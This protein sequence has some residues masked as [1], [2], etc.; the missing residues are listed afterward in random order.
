MINKFILVTLIFSLFLS[1]GCTNDLASNEEESSSQP[2][3]VTEEDD[4]KISYDVP[5][6]GGSFS[7]NDLIYFIL[8]D[9]FNDGDTSNNN[10]SDVDKNSPTSYHG[11]DL[12]GIIDKLDY[13]K[14][15]GATAIWITP[16]VENE[17]GGYHGYWT[18]DFYRVDPHLGTMEDLK[19]LVSEAHKRDMKIL[20][21][22]IVNHTGYKTSWLSDGKHE[23]WFNPEVNISNFNDQE[24]VEKGWLAGLPDLDQNNP[25]VRKFLLD[26]VMWWIDETNIDGMRLDTVRHVPKD[27]WNEFADTIKSKY[28]DF[29]LLGE[30][31]NNSARY[32]EEYHAL[33][34]DGLTNY[35]LFEG[36]RG[37]FTRF[38]KTSPLINALKEQ[39]DFSNPGISG[40]FIDNH[41]NRRL[42]TAGKEYGQQYHRQALA[43]V[44]T[45]PAIPIIYYGTEIGMEGEDDPDNRRDMEWKKTE[46]SDV[47]TFYKILSELRKTHPA[48]V[49]GDFKLLDYDSYF[50][51]YMREKNE[52]NIIVVMNVQNKDKSVVINIPNTTS[53]YSDLLTGTS[54]N[55]NN[56]RLELELKPLDLIIL[57]G[58]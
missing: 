8:T 5:N 19:T 12:K 2:N 42:V 26:N 32:L 17:F 53:Q 20:F 55:V 46:D 50:I 15:L 29:Y 34:I 3:E 4:S 30:V 28:P 43:F 52:D 14:S 54:Y 10:F 38:G 39:T 57:I 16:V 13:I 27:F 1:V 25:E 37:T 56:Q 24:Q 18:S 33:G 41:D 49:E 45:Y 44:M 47:L 48:L 36:I 6:N 21:D 35:P 51:S 7:Q 9:R 11:G 22:H 31:W 40:V 58:N 23:D